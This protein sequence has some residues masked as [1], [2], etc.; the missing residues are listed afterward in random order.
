MA[1]FVIETLFAVT[2]FTEVMIRTGFVVVEP[3]TGLEDDLLRL[4][5]WVRVVLR[6]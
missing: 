5:M 3:T 6:G 2:F 4:W 1:F